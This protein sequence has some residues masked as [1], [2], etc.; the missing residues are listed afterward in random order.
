MATESN[1]MFWGD[2]PSSLLLS[3]S[4]TPVCAV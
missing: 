3:V 2:Q 4:V 1:E